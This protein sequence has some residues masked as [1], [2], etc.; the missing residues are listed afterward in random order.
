MNEILYAS[1][2]WTWKGVMEC[3][4]HIIIAMMVVIIQ[5]EKKNWNNCLA[6]D[7]ICINILSLLLI[8]NRDRF[9]QRIQCVLQLVRSQIG[10]HYV[11]GFAYIFRP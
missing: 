7:P 8:R 4:L 6:W 3:L 11:Y 5:P 2:I 10:Y 9:Y 1:T